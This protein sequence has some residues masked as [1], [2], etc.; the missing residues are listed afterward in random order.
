[1]NER[2]RRTHVE[3]DEAF[4][5][6]VNIIR[7]FVRDEGMLRL[8]GEDVQIMSDLG[9]NSARLVDVILALE[10]ELGIEI[11]DELADKIRTLG[12]AARLIRERVM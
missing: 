10:D 11:D 12:D 3:K 7:P 8:A 1:M 5:K 2:E 4:Q 6:A 9:V